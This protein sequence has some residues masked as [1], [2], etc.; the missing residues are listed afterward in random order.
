MA[1]SMPL[2]DETL[3]KLRHFKQVSIQIIDTVKSGQEETA[4]PD[5]LYKTLLDSRSDGAHLNGL[6]D[7][8]SAGGSTDSGIFAGH[9]AKFG[10][11]GPTTINKCPFITD[12]D[13]F[14]IEHG[15]DR[16]QQYN[17]GTKF[18]LSISRSAANIYQEEY[19][20][21]QHWNYFVNEPDIGPCFLSLRSKVEGKR[22]AFK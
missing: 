16:K 1:C 10:G 20:D 17:E 8:G 6:N 12:E 9:L 11:N 18:N 21:G 7:S 4:I 19:F 13:G 3:E 14:W 15:D 2:V 22:D 5:T